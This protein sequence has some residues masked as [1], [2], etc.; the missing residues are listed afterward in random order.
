ART[1]RVDH[2]C[3]QLRQRTSRANGLVAWINSLAVRMAD[4]GSQGTAVTSGCG[5]PLPGPHSLVATP[6]RSAHHWTNAP[7]LSIAARTVRG[8]PQGPTE[9]LFRR[10]LRR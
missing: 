5:R 1:A 2:R 7:S 3:H 4:L 10:A 6:A 9:S 8:G